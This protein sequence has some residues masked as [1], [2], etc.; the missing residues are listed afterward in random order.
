MHHGAFFA[1]K[2]L[3]RLASFGLIF[4][5]LYA[6]GLAFGYFGSHYFHE[7]QIFDKKR[8]NCHIYNIRVL[9]LCLCNGMSKVPHEHC[10]DCRQDSLLTAPCIPGFKT[11]P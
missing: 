8:V 3:S 7:S 4:L 10:V 1:P 6:K 9:W 2:Y 11:D 5:L